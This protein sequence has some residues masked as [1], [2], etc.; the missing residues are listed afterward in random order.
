M[1]LGFLGVIDVF[2]ISM[3]SSA[4]CAN[5]RTIRFFGVVIL[6]WEGSNREKHMVNKIFQFPWGVEIMV[7][8]DGR[9][10][11]SAGLHDVWEL[12]A[13][14]TSH[15]HRHSGK[16]WAPICLANQTSQ[17]TWCQRLGEYF[18]C[19]YALRVCTTT[20]RIPWLSRCT[21]DD[22]IVQLNSSM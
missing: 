1:P 6:F 13:L 9:E 17:V 8:E 22:S 21:F 5:Q 14:V 10:H 11:V 2:M 15:H 12:A 16:S 18:S 19:M 7:V 3:N 20:L 4:H